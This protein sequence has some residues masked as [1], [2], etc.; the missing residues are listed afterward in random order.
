MFGGAGGNK[1]DM[2]KQMK[3][4]R[5]QVKTME[6]ELAGLNFVGI[7][8]NKLL[9]VTLDGKFQ[10]KSIQIEDELLDKKDKN[11]LEKSIQEAYT[12]ALQDAQAG[13]A[14]QMQAMGGFPGLGM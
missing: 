3:K 6:K 14:K 4:M 2:L 8:K 1:F 5:S 13:A 10:M 9:S 7:S 11:L 12:K